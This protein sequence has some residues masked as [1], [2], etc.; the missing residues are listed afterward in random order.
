MN[1]DEMI[2]AITMIIQYSDKEDKASHVTGRGSPCGCEI[3]RLEH[4]LDSRL[5]DG[6]D[7]S[8]MRMS[9]LAPRKIPGTHSC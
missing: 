8:L 2:T 3:S 6:G 9:P 7:I 4:F 5:T 1:I